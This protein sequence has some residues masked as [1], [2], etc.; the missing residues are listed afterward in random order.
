[1]CTPYPEFRAVPCG[2]VPSQLVLLVRRL[3]RQLVKEYFIY[4]MDVLLAS[5]A[6][7]SLS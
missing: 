6:R 5:A 1:M 3:D 7:R 2:G 4:W